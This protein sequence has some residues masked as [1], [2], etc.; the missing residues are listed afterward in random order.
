VP[1]LTPRLSS[2]WLGLVTPLYARVGRIL[3]DSMRHE[4]VVQEGAALKV[5]PLR[6]MGI[7]QAIAAALRNED[8]EFAQ[9]R[10]S[11][12]LSTAN[13]KRDWG[14]VRFGNRILDTRTVT[15]AATRRPPLRRWNGLA[16]PRVGILATLSAAARLA[17]LARR[18]SRHASRTAG[19]QAAFAR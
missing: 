18:R 2:L 4:T 7:R 13:P 16:D 9:T 11:D 14:G 15:V 17:R 6:P 19:R 12:S 3:V 5:F 1:V 8:R 10:W